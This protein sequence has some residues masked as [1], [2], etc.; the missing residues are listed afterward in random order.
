VTTRLGALVLGRPVERGMFNIDP[1]GR[2]V[3]QLADQAVEVFLA[4]YL[5]ATAPSASGAG[6]QGAR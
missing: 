1:A 6:E 2:G 3:H 4:T 5:P